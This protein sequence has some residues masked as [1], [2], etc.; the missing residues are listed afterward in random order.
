MTLFLVASASWRIAGWSKFNAQGYCKPRI[1]HAELLVLG[2]TY[3]WMDVTPIGRFKTFRSRELDRQYRAP[4]FQ[5]VV[6][7]MGKVN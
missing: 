6:H 2:T 3:T 5:C 7:G 4:I 1:L